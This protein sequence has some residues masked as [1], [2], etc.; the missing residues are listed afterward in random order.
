MRQA[1]VVQYSWRTNICS[2]KQNLLTG[3]SQ[4]LSQVGSYKGFTLSGSCGCHINHRRILL[5]PQHKINIRT[6]NTYRLSQGG[7]IVVLNN[8]VFRRWH[9]SQN[10]CRESF[11][12]ILSRVNL[13]VK[14]KLDIQNQKWQ[15]KA[16]NES[17]Q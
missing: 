5:M 7:S 10:R 13:I 4:N 14:H 6:Q 16:K 1:Q 15:N 17:T 11:F 9:L 8:I 3:H 12:Y 2:Q